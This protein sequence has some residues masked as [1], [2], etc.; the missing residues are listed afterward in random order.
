MLGVYENIDRRAKEPGL[1]PVDVLMLTLDAERYLEKCLDS[2]Y[3][4]IPVNNLIVVDGGSSDNTLSLLR[5]YPRVE[6]HVRPDIRTTGK[7]LELALSRAATEWIAFIDSD[8]ELPE[9]WYEEMSKYKDKYDYFESKRIMHWEFY[10]ENAASVDIDRRSYAIGQLAKLNCFRDY[11]VED[12]YMWGA[13]DM[14]LRQIAEK[15]GYRFGKIANTYHYHHATDNLKYES[16]QVKRGRRL[17]FKEPK[18]EFLD[19]ENREKALDRYRKA[20]VKYLDPEFVYVRGH[21]P[22][23]EMLMKLDAD[24]VKSTSTKWHRVLSEYRKW[25]HIRRLERLA[26]LMMR[27]GAT[28]GDRIR[29]VS[30]R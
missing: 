15:N 11:H 12:D 2:V 18:E 6:I 10:R 5:E 25:R 29:R 7:G 22:T 17:V 16:D 19:R 1:T 3:A 21:E 30:L 28:I 13:T 20:V 26:K 23:L 24:W 14:L 27:H 4:E 9:G 8:M